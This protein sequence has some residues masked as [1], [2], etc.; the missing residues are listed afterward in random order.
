METIIV[1]SLIA[2]FMGLVLTITGYLD[3]KRKNKQTWQKQKN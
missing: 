3:Y 2:S 1:I